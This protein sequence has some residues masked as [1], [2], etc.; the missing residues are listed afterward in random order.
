MSS[1]ISPNQEVSCQPNHNLD[2]ITPTT[3]T[4]DY[5]L[6]LGHHKDVDIIKRIAPNLN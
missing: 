4:R 3:Y 1:I 6:K 5:L 2:R